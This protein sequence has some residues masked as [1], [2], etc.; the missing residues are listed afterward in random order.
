MPACAATWGDCC[1]TWPLKG[2]CGIKRGWMQT[3]H[4]YFPQAGEE[5]FHSILCSHSTLVTQAPSEFHTHTH[6]HTHTHRKTQRQK[7][8]TWNES[9]KQPWIVKSDVVQGFVCGLC[10]YLK[11]WWIH[12]SNAALIYVF[13][14]IRVAL[15]LEIQ[16]GHFVIIKEVC[17]CITELNNVVIAQSVD[18]ATSVSQ[19]KT[20]ANDPP[21]LWLYLG[22]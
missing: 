2:F 14:S 20:A 17:I 13:R 4:C 8:H 3:A 6:T 18:T 16:W 5:P 19:R 11:V 12:K 10:G 7:P 1:F 22:Y 9:E 15:S 21:W